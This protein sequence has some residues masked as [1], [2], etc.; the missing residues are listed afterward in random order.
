MVLVL[1]FLELNSL[2]GEVKLTHKEGI[3][4]NN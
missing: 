2:K 3:W 1:S 4:Y